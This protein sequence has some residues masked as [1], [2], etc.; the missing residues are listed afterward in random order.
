MKRIGPIS[1]ALRLVVPAVVLLL[2]GGAL[3]NV[4]GVARS[5]K[6]DGE[7]AY[8]NRV[9]ERGRQIFRY[10]TFGDEAFWGR[11]LRLHEAIA[12]RRAGG[13]GPGVS[14]K[15]AL[16]VGLKVD[17]RRL[18]RALRRAL[19][20]GRVDLDS[21]RTIL[22]LLKL[23]AVVGVRGRFSR[24]GRR[25]RSV[26][27]TCALCHST[28]NNSLGSGIGRRLD[29]WPNRDLNVGAIVALAP[30][31]K[32][33]A[34][35]LGTDEDTV[36]TVLRSWGPGKFDAALSLD[37]KAF[38][39]DGR[40]AATLI[41]AAYG[42][43]GVNLATYTGNGT[44]TYWNAFVANLEMHG[45]GNFYDPRLNDPERF[46]IATRAGFFNVRNSP[47]LISSKLGPLHVYQLALPVPKPRRGS[48]SRTR[49]RRGKRIFLGKGRC[50]GCHVPP[51]YSEPGYN[52]HRPEEICTDSFQADRS[53]T[54]MY[55]TT[56]L[57]GMRG[58]R[59]GGFYHDGRYPTLRST[60]DH[61]DGCFGLSL[62]ENEKRDLV[63]FLKSL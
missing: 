16:A 19:R 9:L 26:G 13:V 31:L 1:R 45:R 49:A 2:A 17:T 63:E 61:Y 34:D 43:D 25:L 6:R 41:P 46:P 54:G 48:F 10:D 57:R 11:Q 14:P 44:V 4:A 18:P 40:S 8:A 27:I 3:F 12:G 15:T 53:P 24:G 22:A 20:R 50:A 23:D 56:P 29:G 21:P 59:K 30:S 28:V 51:R 60:V 35:L 39:P 42:L 7:Q 38:R 32:P 62:T 36:R 33:F 5:S 52:L 58:R 55:R 47:D 37:G